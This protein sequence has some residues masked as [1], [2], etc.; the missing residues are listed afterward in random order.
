MNVKIHAPSPPQ[1]S[2][3]AAANSS[4]SMV[5]QQSR[6]GR[7][8][9][10]KARILAIDDQF[11]DSPGLL[12]LLHENG[13]RVDVITGANFPVGTRMFDDYQAVIVDIMV[14]QSNGFEGLRNIRENTQIPVLVFSTRG[15][16]EDRIA[17]LHLGADDYVVKPCRPRE[18]VARIRAL[19]RRRSSF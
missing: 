12:R 14:P 17:G 3:L 2:L 15:S 8:Q 11:G 6:T 1:S 19:L 4:R 18:L 5:Q 10:F 7:D 13:L 9:C 16:E